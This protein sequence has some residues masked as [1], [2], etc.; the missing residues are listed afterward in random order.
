LLTIK[1]KTQKPQKD[2]SEFV[3]SFWILENLSDQDKELVV[4]PDGRVDVFFSYSASEPFHVL[5][6]GLEMQP[7]IKVLKAKTKIF[8]ISLNLLAVEYVLE[9]QI[10][11][12][13]NKA[14]SLLPGFWDILEE[15]LEDFDSFCAKVTARIRLQVKFEVDDRKRE[16]F[17]LI[18]SS[19]GNYS[20]A[21]LSEAVFWSSR[22]IN[23]YFN[24]HFGMP[25]KTYC[26]ILRFKASL[27]DLKAGTLYPGGD[28]SDQAHFIK[29]VKKFAGVV[30]TELSKNENDRFIQFSVLSKQ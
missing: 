5:L 23:R 25:L 29:N 2:I 24:R 14:K 22:Q 21:A 11:G 18:Y 15:D 7:A 26:N 3:E 20:V 16:L 1:Y 9:E 13:L 10:S 8:A 12:L 28:F 30:P 17:N 4:I 19:S 6:M 27:N